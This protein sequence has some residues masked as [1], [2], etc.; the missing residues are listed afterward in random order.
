MTNNSYYQLHDIYEDIYQKKF[1]KTWNDAP[2]KNVLLPIFID[3]VKNKTNSILDL[4]C[5]NGFLLDQIRNI[6]PVSNYKQDY[7]GVDFS[8]HAVSRAIKQYKGIEFMQM[9]AMDLDF[10][11]D[12]FDILFS[13]SVVQFTQE[14]LV[15]LKE[16]HRVLKKGGHFFMMIPSLD[17]YRSDR[18]DEGWYEDLGD[19]K[20]R[21]CQWNYYRKKWEDMFSHAGL[22][23][24]GTNESKKYGAI[25]PGVFFFGKA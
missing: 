10:K 6:N 4:G 2:G 7:C 23:L 22:T 5:G 21:L 8:S 20:V 3:F 1:D 18:N 11:D 17:Y 25:N 16:I 15:T 12:T 19:K 9:D 14:P 13:Y 24:Y